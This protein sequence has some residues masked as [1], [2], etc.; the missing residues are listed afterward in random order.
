MRGT[1]GRSAD[2][3][4]SE[5]GGDMRLRVPKILMPRIIAKIIPE[6]LQP[7]SVLNFG[8]ALQNNI[9]L[10]KQTYNAGVQYEW[11]T[12]KNNRIDFKL[13]DLTL[14]DNRNVKNYFNVYT[15]AYSELN[16][17]AKSTAGTSSFFN[18]DNLAIPTGTAGFT[19][20]VLS[21]SSPIVKG[22]TSYLNVQRIEERRDRLTQ[23]NLIIGSSIDFLKNTQTSFFD[24]NFYQVRFQFESAEIWSTYWLNH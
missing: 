16:S 2:D 22:S 10:D 24:E 9:G 1:I 5:I 23:N 13:L 4:I 18:G 20:Y 17:L 15:N 11:K 19:N 3:V 21:E 8:T 7:I 6:N 14:V 12:K